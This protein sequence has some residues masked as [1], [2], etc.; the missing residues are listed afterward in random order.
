MKQWIVIVD[1]L[2]LVVVF[3]REYPNEQLNGE[4]LPPAHES[5]LQWP[6]TLS[7]LYQSLNIDRLQ[8]TM[9][10]ADVNGCMSLHV[11]RVSEVNV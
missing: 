4:P 9:I 6:D 2:H 7:L 5:R 3:V 8:V 1:M 11:P 10:E